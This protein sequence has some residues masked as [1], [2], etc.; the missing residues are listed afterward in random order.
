M[1]I[2]NKPDE[3]I[4][5]LRDLPLNQVAGQLGLTGKRE[6][7]AVMYRNKQF[8]ININGERFFDHKN[9]TGGGGAIDLAKHI[10]GCDFNTAIAWLGGRREQIERQYSFPVAVSPKTEKVSFET[11]LTA[12]GRSEKA[13]PKVRRYLTYGRH[14]PSKLVD[15]LHEQGLIYAND[16]RNYE[17]Y[18][19]PAMVFLHRSW[20]GHVWGASLRDCLP[21]AVFRQTLGDKK[22]A[23]FTVGNLAEANWITAVESPIDAL[24]YYA[25]TGQSNK[26][27]VVSCAGNYVPPELMRTVYAKRPQSLFIVAL[28][29]DAAGEKGYQKA[30]EDTAE[31]TGFNLE[32]QPPKLKDWNLELR[33]LQVQN[34]QTQTVR[35]TP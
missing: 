15:E 4:D 27:A 31:W 5:R 3:A 7:G 20:S 25:I 34:R 22:T 1:L 8:A 18:P 11:L 6:G 17:G 33:Q 14:L 32:N 12:Q 9:G 10:L 29:N 28:D 21:Q 19:T 24:S 23:W 26:Q 13:W 35:I 16:H 30:W 2:K